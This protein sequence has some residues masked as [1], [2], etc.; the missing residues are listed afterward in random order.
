MKLTIARIVHKKRGGTT[1]GNHSH[2]RVLNVAVLMA[3]HLLDM[4]D[5]VTEVMKPNM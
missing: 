3:S 2:Y 4:C 5:T 1:P